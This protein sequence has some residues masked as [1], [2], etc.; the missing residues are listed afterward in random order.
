MQ[1]TY[2]MVTSMPHYTKPKQA[3]RFVQRLAIHLHLGDGVLVPSVGVLKIVR[4]EITDTET[5][6]EFANG[7]QQSY[8]HLESVRHTNDHNHCHRCFLSP[9]SGHAMGGLSLSAWMD[10]RNTQLC[11]LGRLLTALLLKRYA[12]MQQC[13]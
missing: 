8:R 10:E 1:I 6:V 7:T 3:S 13:I 2:E 11:T 5:V 4:I 12:F 9:T